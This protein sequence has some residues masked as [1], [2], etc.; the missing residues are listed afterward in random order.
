MV[1][2]DYPVECDKVSNPLV[3]NYVYGDPNR[4]DE[5]KAEDPQEPFV[6][7]SGNAAGGRFSDGEGQHFKYLSDEVYFGKKTLIFDITDAQPGPDIWG[8]P[9]GL[10]VRVMNGWWSNTYYEGP[11]SAGLWEFPITDVV[12][13][14]CAQGGDGK[15]LDLLMRAGSVTIR[16]VYYEE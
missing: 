9:T 13:S 3:K 11:I 16:S 15:D 1:T 10:T 5:E 12:A 2:V 14:D 7:G 4:S 6:L 8:G